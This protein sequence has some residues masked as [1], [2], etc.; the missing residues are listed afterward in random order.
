MRQ[1]RLEDHVAEEIDAGRHARAEHRDAIGA[2]D[3]ESTLVLNSLILTVL[4][5]A[6][7]RIDRIGREAEIRSL[8]ARVGDAGIEERRNLRRQEWKIQETELARAE[9]R[10]AELGVEDAEA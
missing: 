2:D 10:D 9:K 7:C 8:V 4:R 3:P 6:R 5:N 1:V